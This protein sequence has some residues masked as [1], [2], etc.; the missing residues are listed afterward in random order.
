M[1]ADGEAGLTQAETSAGRKEGASASWS[2]SRFAGDPSAVAALERMTRVN[3]GCRPWEVAPDVHPARIP[4]HI[5]VIMDGNGRWAEA[6]GFPRSFGHRAGAGAVREVV[7]ACGDL[8]VEQVTLFSFSAE[9][10]SRPADEVEALWG[11]CVEYCDA[12]RDA[13]VREGIRFRVIGRRQ[14]LPEGVAEAIDRLE[15]ATSACEGP[16][17]CLAINYGGRQEIAD[18]ARRLAE[19]VRAG[20]LDPAS[21]DEEA[22]A[23]ALLTA[24]MPDPDLLVRTA[25]EMRVSN[26]LLW[27]ISYAELCV[28]DACW[29]DVTR[30]HM[31]EAVRA[32]AGRTRRFGGVP[33][34]SGGVGGG[35]A[36]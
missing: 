32:Y 14:G 36:A 12:H 20:D 31:Y 4:R 33:G 9:N 3:P 8:G 5:A 28:L 22:F 19:R 15:R 1:G 2:G 29:P 25:G 6:R 11:L 7:E 35:G 16:T 18:A 13:L 17:L 10:W 27:Q 23:S 24:G 26:F 21:I 34:D 30:E